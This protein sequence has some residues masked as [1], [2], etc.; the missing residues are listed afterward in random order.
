MRVTSSWSCCRRA[1]GPRPTAARCTSSGHSTH[2]KRNR[3]PACASG[4]PSA[5]AWQSVPRMAI[6]TTSC[7]RPPIAGCTKTSSNGAPAA[8][9]CR[10][11]AAGT[12]SS[13]SPPS[14]FALYSVTPTSPSPQACCPCW[15]PGSQTPHAD[16][17]RLRRAVRLTLERYAST[18][19]SAE[20]RPHASGTPRRD[21]N[22]LPKCASRREW[23]QRVGPLEAARVLVVGA[24]TAGAR[25][26][27]GVTEWG[28]ALP[29]IRRR[30]LGSG[31]R[32]GPEP[33]CP[34]SA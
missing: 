6:P 19:R 26:P 25:N 12:P 1:S 8:A 16:V 32:P 10:S 28:P 17:T 22:R 30:G 20:P 33:L 2:W 34:L 11:R 7:S 13:W 5:W 18:G 31:G 27:R 23:T 24:V 21:R 3:A 4:R 14:R 29:P 9:G 15:R